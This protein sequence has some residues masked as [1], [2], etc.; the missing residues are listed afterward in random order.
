M[1]RFQISSETGQ[2]TWVEMHDCEDDLAA[3]RK[4]YTLCHDHHVAIWQ[5]RRHVAAIKRGCLPPAP[6]ELYAA[7]RP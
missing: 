4:G 1:Y 3:L 6:Q 2:I 7:G 5:D